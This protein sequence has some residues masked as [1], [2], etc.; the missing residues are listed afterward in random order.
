[1]KFGR[2]T[3]V[4]ALGALIVATGAAG[5]GG[6]NK[7]T[8]K[9]PLSQSQFVAKATAICVP[10]NKRID[11]AA[12]KYLGGGK[13]TATDFD[14]FVHRALVPITRQQ[15]SQFRQLN[16]PTNE[17]ATYK[18]LVDKLQSITDRLD[19]NPQLLSKPGDPFAGLKAM[20]KQIGLDTWC[21]S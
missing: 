8:H 6:D 19:A 10:A 5:C 1:M 18:S 16:P 7:G 9:K 21:E 3:F 11:V 13:P 2:S 4:V 14:Q 20:A 12:K 17:A 15:V